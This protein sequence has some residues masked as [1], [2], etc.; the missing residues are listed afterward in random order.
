M[1]EEP[2]TTFLTPLGRLSYPVLLKGR[3]NQQGVDKWGVQILITPEEFKKSGAELLAAVTRIGKEKFGKTWELKT[4]KNKCIQ[5][6]DDMNVKDDRTKGLICL[7]CTASNPPIVVGPDGNKMDAEAINRI[8]GGHW[9]RAVVNIYAYDK[10]GNK[11]VSL[12]LNVLQYWKPDEEFG[13][14]ASASLALIDQLEVPVSEIAIPKEVNLQ[15]AV[16]EVL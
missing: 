1:T 11:G 5:K 16:D 15:S 13:I 14:G 10:A 12:G 6:T 9:G 4:S 7:K 2:K 8:R 3:A